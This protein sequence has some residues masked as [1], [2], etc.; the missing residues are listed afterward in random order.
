MIWENVPEHVEI[1]SKAGW[2]EGA[3]RKPFGWQGREWIST[4]RSRVG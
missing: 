3:E 1:Q 4:L 2:P